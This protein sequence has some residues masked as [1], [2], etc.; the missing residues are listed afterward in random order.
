M[1]ADSSTAHQHFEL[2]K[3]TLQDLGL[4]QAKDKTVP[5]TDDLVWLGVRFSTQDM[6]MSIPQ[7]NLRRHYF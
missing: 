3:Q 2:L 5:P 4:E 7:R 1:A 6:T